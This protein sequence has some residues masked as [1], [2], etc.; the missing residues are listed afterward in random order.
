MKDMTDELKMELRST[1]NSKINI[2]APSRIYY[3]EDEQHVNK[4]TYDGD[5]YKAYQNKT[6]LCSW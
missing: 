4:K 2:I 1:L 5:A 3:T 6:R